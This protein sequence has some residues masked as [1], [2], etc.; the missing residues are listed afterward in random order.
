MLH[1][2]KRGLVLSE[3]FTESQ[4]SLYDQ[5]IYIE[6][7]NSKWIKIFHHNNP[8]NGLFSQN[9]TFDTGAYKDS[10]RWFCVSICNYLSSWEFL[11]EQ[12]ADKDSNVEKYR[13]IQNI[14]PYLA[15]YEDT[16]PSKITKINTGYTEYSL[17]GMY[18]KGGE[19]ELILNNNVKGNWFGATGSWTEYLGGIPYVNKAITTGYADLYIRIDNTL[20]NSN[21]D[22][23]KVF[24]N[25]LWTKE[26]IEI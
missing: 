21:I 11:I 13:F 23:F 16:I 26:L 22:E 18:A 4:L 25:A 7:D 24:D 17:G 10:D 15:T 20:N 12:K 3:L 8:S 19:A 9:D 14:N 1:I 5:T 6:S 2:E